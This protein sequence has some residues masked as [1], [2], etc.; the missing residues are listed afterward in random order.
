MNTVLQQIGLMGIVPVVVIDD[1][2]NAVPLGRALSEAGLPCAEVTFRT[3][4]AAGAIGAISRA[5]PDMLIGAGT[6]LSVQQV[7]IAI[8]AG[9]KFIVCPGVNRSVV[10]YCMK[11]NIPITPGV[12]TPTEI[13]MALD[14][15]VGVMKFFPAEASGGVPYLKAISAP[16]KGVKFIPTGGIDA[17]NLLSYLKLGSVLACGGSWMV[18]EDLIAEGKFGEIR[19]LTRQA[20]CMMLGF[21]VRLL[22]MSVPDE[23]KAADAAGAIREFLCM[24]NGNNNGHGNDRSVNVITQASHGVDGEFLVATTSIARAMEFARRKGAE[25]ISSA[26]EDLRVSVDVDFGRFAVRFVQV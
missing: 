8:D 25:E 6:V 26:P 22:G 9:A 7:R 23:R 5:L 1:V 16:F 17:G 13:G 11:E 19:D 3:D 18:R 24:S 20:L 4:A 14:L 15:G 21:D 10:E 12:A 2:K